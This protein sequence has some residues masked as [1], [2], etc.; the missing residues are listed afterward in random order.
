MINYWWKPQLLQLSL[1]VR[2]AIVTE[3]PLLLSLCGGSF[4]DH[5]EHKEAASKHC[6]T[7]L[8]G[9]VTTH[10]TH[11]QTGAR[12]GPRTGPRGVQL[13]EAQTILAWNIITWRPCNH[14]IVMDRQSLYSRAMFNVA[15][16][17]NVYFIFKNNDFIQ[18]F[19]TF[20]RSNS[21]LQ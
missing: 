11:P 7:S 2:Y 21:T 6:Q 5:K 20:V 10:T 1:T 3:R 13:R 15:E 9:L 4:K 14:T 18:C 16:A 19:D 17:Y 12:G 8:A